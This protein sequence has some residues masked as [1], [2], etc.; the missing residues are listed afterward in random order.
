MTYQLKPGKM[1]VNE[2]LGVTKDFVWWLVKECAMKMKGF[3]LMTKEIET[4]TKKST[5]KRGRKGKIYS[6]FSERSDISEIFSASERSE[7]HDK[8]NREE[9]R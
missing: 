6:E 9:E 7:V 8:M 2:R 1:K 5:R 3:R 4:S